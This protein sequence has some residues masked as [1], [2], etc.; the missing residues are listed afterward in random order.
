[1]EERMVPD[2]FY[3]LNAEE[4]FAMM[5]VVD[6]NSTP[7]QRSEAFR[8]IKE[9]PYADFLQT[10]YWRTISDCLLQRHPT[11]CS[12]LK[13]P[14]TQVHHLTYEHH[15]EEHLYLLDLLPVCRLC[16]EI[17]HE[18]ADV[19]RPDVALNDWTRQQIMKVAKL[20]GFK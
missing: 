11:C 6:R 16:H 5:L 7:K 20:K 14:S 19:Y 1:M 10:T 13:A 4:R 18:L 8:T 12:C 17:K 2:S 9:I 15:G 3:E